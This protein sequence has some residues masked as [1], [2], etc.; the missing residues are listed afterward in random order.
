MKMYISASYYRHDSRC[1]QNI[2]LFFGGGSSHEKRLIKWRCDFFF[3]YFFQHH[4]YILDIPSSHFVRSEMALACSLPSRQTHC[5]ITRCVMVCLSSL[6]CSYNYSTS[7]IL[8]WCLLR[9]VISVS[10]FRL[11]ILQMHQASAAWIDAAV[12]SFLSVWCFRLLLCFGN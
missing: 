2:G 4:F 11:N 1:W 12:N 5:I 3:L 9:L 8:P 7:K 6:S 10:R